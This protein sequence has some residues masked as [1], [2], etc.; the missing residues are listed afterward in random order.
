MSISAARWIPLIALPLASCIVV[1]GEG[2]WDGHGRRTVRGSGIAREE[3]RQVPEF[4]A[5]ELET[6]ATV[7]VSV[8]T[9]SSLHLSGD[10]NLLARVETSVHDGVLSID[11]RGS[12]DF[13]CDLEIEIGTPALERF[14][15]EGSGDVQIH[16]LENDR[17]EL[18]IEGS[19]TLH[20][21]GAA[22]RLIGSIEGSGS[23]AVSELRAEDASLS[24]EGSGSM[25]VRVQ[26]RLSYSIEGSGD[27]RYD[28][29]PELG[30]R[31][32][33]SGNIERVRS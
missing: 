31:I 33:G 23:L 11:T 14:T 27:I 2:E 13:R 17:V 22:R 24:I 1:V 18:A 28:G 9:A 21:Q 6:G 8:G 12:C 26:R 32:E 3:D 29:Q 7:R 16:G 4:S 20:A 10:D 30:G 19:G 5:I 15:I 25:S